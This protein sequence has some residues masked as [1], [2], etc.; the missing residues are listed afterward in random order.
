[1]DVLRQI[2]EMGHFSPQ[3]GSTSRTPSF[4]KRLTA[5]WATGLQLVIP[6]RVRVL[7][8]ATKQMCLT[9]QMKAAMCG[10]QLQE[11]I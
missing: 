8:T 10:P 11:L 2:K 4:L 9:T 6:L 7:R 5:P 1:M 3:P